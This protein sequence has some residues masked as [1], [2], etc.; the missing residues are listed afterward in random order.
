MPLAPLFH[1]AA[2]LVDGPGNGED[3]E[4]MACRLCHAFNGSAPSLSTMHKAARRG[5]EDAA[6]LL[7]WMTAQGIEPVPVHPLSGPKALALETQLLADPAGFLAA[8]SAPYPFTDAGLNLGFDA[9]WTAGMLD[10]GRTRFS[11][12]CD[13][14]R[15]NTAVLVGNGPSLKKTN[16][17]L[18]DGQDVYISNYAIRHPDLRRLAKGVAV[19]NRLV[20][21]QEPHVFQT[22][23]LWK[24]HPVWLGDI[25]RDTPETVWLNALG[26][27]LFFSDAL[28]KSIAWHASVSF[29]WMQILYAAGYRRILLVGM[30]NA[31]IQPDTAREGDR[32]H[33][34]GD[35]PNHFDPNYFKG[36]VWQAADTQHM[37]QAYT[38]ARDHFEADERKIINCSEGGKLDTFPR[39][40]LVRQ[41]QEA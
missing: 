1:A 29:F 3:T 25:L 2:A 15:S 31:Y 23:N 8:A 6:N 28:E 33:Q 39:D 37:A 11:A 7:G 24:F 38:I 5:D 22:N 4:K 30:D 9:E 35:D 40:E 18:L 16:L 21:A 32:I 41:L 13:D 27:E 36:K 17:G 12:F 34:E 10:F 14:R 20:A 19:S 26:G